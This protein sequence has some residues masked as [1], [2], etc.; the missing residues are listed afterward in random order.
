MDK[1]YVFICKGLI[2]DTAIYYELS[3]KKV[4]LSNF[5]TFNSNYAFLAL[6]F[7]P[8]FKI[9]KKETISFA[10]ILLVVITTIVG[11]CLGLLPVFFKKQKEIVGKKI[12]E[13][14][15]SEDVLLFVSRGEKLM[16]PQVISYIVLIAFTLSNYRDLYNNNSIADALL[17]ILLI[18]LLINI[19]LQF[20]FIRRN[21]VYKKLKNIIELQ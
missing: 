12:E 16:T 18:A 6:V 4:I 7:Y 2:K 20:D 9:L 15:D 1:N 3:S 8:F 11:A 5:N 10:P 21:K 19:W 13:I 14:T 17:S